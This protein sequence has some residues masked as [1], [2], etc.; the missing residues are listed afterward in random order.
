MQ[1]SSSS[2]GLAWR[3]QE[4]PEEEQWRIAF[5]GQP[6]TWG[7]FARWYAGGAA[8]PWKEAPI[9]TG[10][11]VAQ[12]HERRRKADA[13][14][15]V[16]C[17]N[18]AERRR[19]TLLIHTPRRGTIEHWPPKPQEAAGDLAIADRAEVDEAPA[20]ELFVSRMQ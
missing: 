13:I 17:R 12:A 11:F 16:E 9:A 8:R 20:I 19:P 7:E 4:I 6:Y 10:Y 5:D 18:R 2:S 3:G 15:D 14:L 1:S